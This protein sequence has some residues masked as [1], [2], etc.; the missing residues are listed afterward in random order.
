ME[1]HNIDREYSTTSVTSSSSFLSSPPSS[2]IQLVNNIKTN[3]SN[4]TTTNTYITNIIA[5]EY[6]LEQLENGTTNDELWNTC[7]REV[8]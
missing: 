2:A 8:S 6:T 7:Q 1:E 3:T 4:S 5:S